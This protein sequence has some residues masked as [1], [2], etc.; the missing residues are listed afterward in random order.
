MFWE[1]RGSKREKK[2]YISA[3]GRGVERKVKEYAEEYWT[4]VLGE[5]RGAL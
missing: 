4:Y 1:E 2:G 5:K 3:K